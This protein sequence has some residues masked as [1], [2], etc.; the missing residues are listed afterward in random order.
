M[1]NII[2]SKE[3]NFWCGLRCAA[4]FFVNFLTPKYILQMSTPHKQI[5]QDQPKL[6]DAILFILLVAS[7]FIFINPLLI[8]LF[9]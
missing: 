3:I 6:S 5:H 7:Y 9:S 8:K 1:Q 2:Y 4:F